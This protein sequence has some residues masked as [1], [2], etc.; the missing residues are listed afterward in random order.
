MTNNIVVHT[1]SLYTFVLHIVFQA[2][3]NI[4]F[5]IDELKTSPSPLEEHKACNND[6]Q[7]KIIIIQQH[8]VPET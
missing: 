8:I 7:I 2:K 6:I 5:N 1:K 3:H 4:C